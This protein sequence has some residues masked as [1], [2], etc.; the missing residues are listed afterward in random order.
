P[1]A[2]PSRGPMTATPSRLRSRKSSARMARTVGIR[3]VQIP[4]VSRVRQHLEQPGNLGWQLSEPC[5]PAA[6]VH[7]GRLVAEYDSAR[8]TAAR[9]FDPIGRN[10]RSEE[11][12]GRKQL[13][14]ADCSQVTR[15]NIHV[16][17]NRSVF[18]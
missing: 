15:H 4:A 9:A 16:A 6:D 11:G 7:R 3:A 2:P 12:Q 18:T 5:A 14:S 17:G 10:G 8:A 1:A 13:S